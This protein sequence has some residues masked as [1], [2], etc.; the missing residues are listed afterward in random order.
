ME[1]MEGMVGMIGMLGVEGMASLINRSSAG[2][3][4]PTPPSTGQLGEKPSVKATSPLAV[5]V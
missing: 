5:S 4:V 1:G 3:A 2:R